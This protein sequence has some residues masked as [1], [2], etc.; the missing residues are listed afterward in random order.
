MLFHVSTF[1]TLVFISSPYNTLEDVK[2]TTS[3]LSKKI[4]INPIRR[5]P[6][7]QTQINEF[8]YLLFQQLYSTHYAFYFRIKIKNTA[9]TMIRYFIWVTILVVTPSVTASGSKLKLISIRA[10]IRKH[11]QNNS[12]PDRYSNLFLT[13]FQ[14]MLLVRE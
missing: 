2:V 3:Y 13:L 6:Y 10:A 9:V 4:N 5:R 12:I 11:C 14:V 7:F 8:Q 1:Q